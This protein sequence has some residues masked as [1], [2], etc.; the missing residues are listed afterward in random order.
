VTEGCCTF[1]PSDYTHILHDWLSNATEPHQVAVSVTS[2]LAGIVLAWG[3]E[4]MWRVI[5]VTACAASSA[6]MVHHELSSTV[7]EL[8]IVSETLVL[9]AVAGVSGIGVCSGFDGAQ[10][11]LGAALGIMLTYD[12]ASGF[13][14]SPIF[15]LLLCHI[16]A[17]CG[18]LVLSVWPQA[19]LKTLAPLAGAWLAACGIETLGAIGVAKS[20]GN[21][22]PTWIAISATH[23]HGRGLPLPSLQGCAAVGAALVHR[24]TGR[25]GSAIVC[26]M[27]G[28]VIA[29]AMDQHRDPSFMKPQ[30]GRGWPAAGCVLWFTHTAAAAWFNLRTSPDWE[31]DVKW[32]ALL[33]FARGR[34]CSSGG[35]EEQ[36]GATRLLGAEGDN[37]RPR[38]SGARGLQVGGMKGP[39]PGNPVVPQRP[40]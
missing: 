6:F 24:A 28:I 34:G 36:E 27:A 7:D 3:G 29:A 38:P 9:I 23:V 11:V 39:R 33:D 18:I 25:R 2:L 35:D 37:E 20:T 10:F 21:E 31:P 32:V 5:F 40:P 8:S 26:I 15:M 22:S 16:G 12:L 17:V 13:V 1:W 14:T 19:F 30:V 4:P